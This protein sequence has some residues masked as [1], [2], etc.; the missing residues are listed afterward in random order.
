[1]RENAGLR[2][3]GYVMSDFKIAMSAGAFGVDL[4]LDLRSLKFTN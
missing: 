3:L 2:V 4:N 1:M